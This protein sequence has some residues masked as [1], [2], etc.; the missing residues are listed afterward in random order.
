MISLKK[1]LSVGCSPNN[2][3]KPESTLVDA[4]RFPLIQAETLTPSEADTQSI[5]LVGRGVI[6]WVVGTGDTRVGIG[7]GAVLKLPPVCMV[8]LVG[9]G[10][11]VV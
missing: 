7:A 10:G 2:V 4:T 1:I 9:S 11:G 3:Y 8:K 6:T 5:C